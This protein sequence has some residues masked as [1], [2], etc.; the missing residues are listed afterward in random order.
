MASAGCLGSAEGGTWHPDNFAPTRSQ[1]GRCL[2][3]LT[4]R[5]PLRGAHFGTG[6]HRSR[7]WPA[8]V[9]QV[10]CTMH[11]QHGEDTETKILE[12]WAKQ[13]Q[14]RSPLVPRPPETTQ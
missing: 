10:P 1:E 3:M 4:P 14:T 6:D 8:P 12:D 13:G 9:C 7:N 11:T 5:R 2:H